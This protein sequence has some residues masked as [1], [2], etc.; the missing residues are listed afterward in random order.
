MKIIIVNYRY[1]I[2]GGPERYLFNI[3]DLLE[4]NGHEVIP[5]SVKSRHNQ[6]SGY[7]Q[8]FLSAVGEGKEV[9]FKE[10]N[11]F[12]NEHGQDCATEK[13]TEL[14]FWVAGKAEQEGG[15]VTRGQNWNDRS[16]SARRLEDRTS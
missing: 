9:Y 4:K 15:V 13:C 3:K 10:Y 12:D 11:K 5:F 6:P 2:S 14:I 7:E 16:D 8:Y 1:F